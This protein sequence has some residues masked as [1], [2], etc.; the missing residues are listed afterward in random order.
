MEKLN[1]NDLERI[2]LNIN[3]N[4]QNNMI[5]LSELDSTIGDG[6]HGVTIA[7]G[8]RNVIEAINKKEQKNISELLIDVGN[9]LSSSMG[10]VSGII[11]SN[12]FKAMGTTNTDNESIS[13][14]DLYNMFYSALEKIKE[15]GGAKV[16]EKTIIDSME[17]AV[18]E[19][20][21]A[22]NNRDTIKNAF[23]K[24]TDAAK[25][26]AESTKGMIA[27]KGRARYLG[28]RSIGYQDAGATSFYIIIKSIAEVL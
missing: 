22:A 4:I 11:F 14:D 5:Y 3:N 15:V 6:D 28:E 10:G 21:V 12:L 18:E 17:P 13:L 7:R 9:V 2:I 26:G 1:L 25:K 24:M 19:L 8:F 16:G 23:L 20:K 27:K